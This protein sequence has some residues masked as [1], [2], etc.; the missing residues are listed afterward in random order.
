MQPHDPNKSFEAGAVT[1]LA[2]A[3]A[4]RRTPAAEEEKIILTEDGL[5]ERLVDSINGEWRYCEQFKAW[6][7]FQSGSWIEEKTLLV[8]DLVR[9]QNREIA[10]PLRGA[11]KTKS[12]LGAASTISS[13][14]RLSRSDRR[15]A[16]VPEQF[17]SDPMLLNCPAGTV[18][19][20]TGELREHRPTDFCT[21]STAVTP[22]FTAETPQFDAFLLKI[23]DGNLANIAYL[24]R[25]FGYC[26]SGLVSEHVFCFFYGLGANGKSVLL[27]LMARILGSY[28][29]RALPATFMTSQLDK[30]PVDTA[31][32]EGL[33]LVVATEI[34]R[35][36]RWDETKLK[37]LTGGD[38]VT[39][40]RMRQD[41]RTFS[42][43]FKLLFAGNDKP[44]LA[45]VDT[46][47]R[48]RMHLLPFVI[49][50][51]QEERVADLDDKLFRE[52]GP[53]ILA[54]A[55]QGILDW[56]KI[57]LNPPPAIVAATDEYLDQEDA[58]GNW[59]SDCAELQRAAVTQTSKAYECFKNW[60]E[61]SG[62]RA[63][64]QTRFSGE[65]KKKGCTSDK[66]GGQR[67]IVGIRLNAAV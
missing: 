24:R 17:D 5:A 57:G 33:R 19:L 45:A 8:Y 16:A 2:E 49:T 47:I 56:Q 13:I 34:E 42:P 30:H 60:T 38:P 1:S 55:I 54:W 4:K 36:R 48:R 27:N 63:M 51:P 61:R 14:E 9:T 7:H 32:F 52:E 31:I 59:I 20:R 3:R 39:A 64:S 46:A 62:E 37:S 40:R 35:G 21:K 53:A 50:I 22:D 15:M 41:P 29:G 26:L 25:L 12:W 28:A 11:K 58:I 43:T 65:L 66:Q 44:S 18:D 23:M 67:V 10:E 6:F